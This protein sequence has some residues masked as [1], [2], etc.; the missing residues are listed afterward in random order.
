MRILV[1]NAGSS[2]LKFGVFGM[3]SEDSRVLRGKMTQSRH[4]MID[5]R[6]DAPDKKNHPRK[7]A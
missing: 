1:F 7:T 4:V 2:S 3:N 6:G 5:R